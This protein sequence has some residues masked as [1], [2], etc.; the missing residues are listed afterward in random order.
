VRASTGKQVWQAD[1]GENFYASPVCVNDCIYLVTR[2]GEVIVLQAGPK[3]K[4]LARHTLPEK[5]DATP[6]IANGHM[7]IRTLNHLIC[8]GGTKAES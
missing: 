2:E 3:Y 5:T 7:Y 4:V 8:I 6:A 1:L